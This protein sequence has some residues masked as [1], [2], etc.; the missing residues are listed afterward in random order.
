M[1]QDIFQGVAPVVT[2]QYHRTGGTKITIPSP[3]VADMGIK[4]GTKFSVTY[5]KK[6]GQILYTKETRR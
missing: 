6:T 4:P 3:I 1:K 2:A 5:N